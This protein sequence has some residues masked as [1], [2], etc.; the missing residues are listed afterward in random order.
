MEGGKGAL[1]TSR[2]RGGDQRD[3]ELRETK[4]KIGGSE[5]ALGRRTFELEIGEALAQD[6]TRAAL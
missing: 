1:A 6:W 4:R 2:E 3:V 5:R